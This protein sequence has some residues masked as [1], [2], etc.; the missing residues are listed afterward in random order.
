[1]KPAPVYVKVK[2][3]LLGGKTTYFWGE[4]IALNSGLF[5]FTKC[6][7][8]GETIPDSTLEIFLAHPSDIIWEKPATLNLKYN[9]LELVQE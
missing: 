9:E 5:R 1:M 6:S 7:R 8:S 3:R 4:K 2:L